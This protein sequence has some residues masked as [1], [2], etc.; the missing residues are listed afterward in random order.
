MV[1]VSVGVLSLPGRRGG[2]RAKGPCTLWEPMVMAG[3]VL[4]KQQSC[5]MN[6]C[7]VLSKNIES[8]AS[9]AALW[10]TTASPWENGLRLVFALKRGFAAC[11]SS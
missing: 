2:G 9:R 11:S 3:L 1:R 4:Q 6:L 5:K 10:E 8:P 7:T